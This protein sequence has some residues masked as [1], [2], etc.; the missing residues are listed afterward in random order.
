MKHIFNNKIAE[1]FFN[2]PT[3]YDIKFF[4]NEICYLHT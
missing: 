2:M 4:S 1:Q 3:K